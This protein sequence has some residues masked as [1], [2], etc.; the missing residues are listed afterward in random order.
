MTDSN[1][2]QTSG[3]SGSGL[4]RSRDPRDGLDWF[5]RAWCHVCCWFRNQSPV[6]RAMMFPALCCFLSYF[7]WRFPLLS[8]RFFFTFLDISSYFCHTFPAL[9]LY[10]PLPVVPHISLTYSLGLP[11]KLTNIC[12]KIVTPLLQFYSDYF[13]I[14][15]AIVSNGSQRSSRK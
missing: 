9:F 14:I 5:Q 7:P 12:L 8:P 3:N 4:S 1:Y 15:L 10:S 2:F 11:M 13:C 6:A